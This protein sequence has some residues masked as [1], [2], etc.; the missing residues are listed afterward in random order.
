M[1]LLGFDIIF[2]TALHNIPQ[3]GAIPLTSFQ[4]HLKAIIFYLQNDLKL[5]YVLADK[6][7]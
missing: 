2:Y 4:I 3:K 7:Y 6:K 5:F 1:E